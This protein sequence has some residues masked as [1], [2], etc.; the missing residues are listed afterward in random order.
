MNYL[1]GNILV[2]KTFDTDQGGFTYDKVGY[3]PALSVKI[4]FLSDVI[5]VKKFLLSSLLYR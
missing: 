3:G 1:S 2:K 5:R 4:L